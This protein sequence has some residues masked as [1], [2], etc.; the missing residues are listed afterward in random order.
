MKQ[1]EEGKTGP[2]LEEFRSQLTADRLAYV[3]EIRKQLATIS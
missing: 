3:E 2:F 1:D